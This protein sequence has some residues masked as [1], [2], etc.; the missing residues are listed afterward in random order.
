MNRATEYNTFKLEAQAIKAQLVVELA[1][2][3]SGLPELCNEFSA[4]WLPVTNLSWTRTAIGSLLLA[5]LAGASAIPPVSSNHALNQR[6]LW[7]NTAVLDGFRLFETKLL[8][9]LGLPNLKTALTHLTAQADDWLTKGPYTVTSKT[10]VPPGGDKHDYASQA[11]YWWP[12]PDTADGCPY[13]QRDGVR[14]PEVDNYTDHGDRGDMF[15][16]S[17]ILS[18]AWYYTGK[19]EYAT[20]AA[21]ILRTWF[22]TPETRMNPNLNHAQIIPCKNT[23]RAIGIIDFSQQYTAVLDAAAILASGAPGWTKS[24]VSGFQ[25]WNV[26]FL[27]W[28]AN[29]PFGI[30]ESAAANNH[31]TF[32]SMQK[33]GI[34]VFVG[35]RTLAK[36]E[37]VGM[38][39]R[40]DAYISPNGS[41]PLELV[42]TRSWHYSTFDLVAYTRIA[43]IGKK[44]GVDLWKYKGPQG[45]SIQGAVDFILAGATG[46]AAAWVYPE[47]EFYGYAASDIVHAAADAGNL[48]ALKAVSKLQTP[49]GGDLW[50]L[51]PAVEQLDAISN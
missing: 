13:I 3:G 23:G 1:F 29:S 46:G 42:R 17:Y 7:P 6:G 4:L 40:I 24:D 36:Q 48:K 51:R 35:N 27:D 14:N 39:A 30:E 28:L 25:Q 33:A 34:A 31:G 43:D 32:A 16:S 21:D 41:Q 38:K 9:E 37:A 47:L 44:V 22:L 8:L 49:P 19:K 10:S 5:P 15:Q 45:Q 18:L 11:P 26:Q 12:N 2:A 20:H 50:A